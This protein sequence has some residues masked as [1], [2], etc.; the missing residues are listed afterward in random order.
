[1]VVW[2]SR[3]IYPLTV[4]SSYFMPHGPSRIIT[5]S[6]YKSCI[7]RG[8]VWREQLRWGLFCLQNERNRGLGGGNSN[9]FGI[10]TPKI[11]EMIQFDVRIFFKRVVQPPTSQY[12]ELCHR[13]SGSLKQITGNRNLKLISFKSVPGMKFQRK[14]Q[15]TP[16]TYPRP[17]TTCL[18][19]DSFIFGL[20]GYLGYVPGVCWNFLRK[21]QFL[22][23]F[24]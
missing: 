8:D 20:L 6:I 13:T 23:G 9:V 2:G 15:Q 17:F 21:F 10:F 18:W 22:I 7:W 5:G 19:R 3:K 16:G 11:G 24:I 12:W 1:M 4:V 14:F